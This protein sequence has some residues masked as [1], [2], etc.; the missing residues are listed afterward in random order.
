MA[1]RFGDDWL[2]WPGKFSRTDELPGEP[3]ATG[4]ELTVVEFPR[5]GAAVAAGLRRITL[6]PNGSQPH[7]DR[8]V[9]GPPR[10]RGST[11]CGAGRWRRMAA[12]IAPQTAEASAAG[13]LSESLEAVREA[14]D[15][16]RR[17]D[18]RRVWLLMSLL[19][20]TVRGLIA[21]NLITDPAGLSGH[22]RRGV[23]RLDAAARRPPRRPRVPTCPRHVRHGLRIR[24]TATS[25]APRSPR[26]WPYCSPA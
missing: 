10:R 3:G 14:L 1:D 24:R 11:R 12:L 19:V 17:P 15:Y 5:P 13:F 16:E 8:Q 18:H 26:A 7:A 2:I 9:R 20:A 22:Q 6:R 4:R 23:R 25:S 21:D